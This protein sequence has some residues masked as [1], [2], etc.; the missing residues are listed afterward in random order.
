MI[1]ELLWLALL[2]ATFAGI[3]L[4]YKFFGKTG[5]YAWM[6][7]AIILANI[8]VLKTIGIFGFVTA[9]GNIVYGTTFLTTDILSEKYGQK[10]ARK[11]VWI[12]FFMLI[13][14]TIVMQVCLLFAP[15]ESDFSQGSLQTIFGFLPR[16]AFA[17]LLAFIV[18]Q[19]HDVWSFGLWK[20]KTKGKYLW[21]RNNASTLVSQLIDNVIFTAIAFTGFLSWVPFLNWTQVFDWSI[22]IQIFFVSYVMKFIVA[23][24]DTPFV[25]WAKKITPRE[26]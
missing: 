9:L 10:A 7:V 6:A 3:M 17:S 14:T 1:N 21:L 25:Y 5:L 12:G 11:A 18:S 16:I 13:A 15:H 23:A 2:L 4:A 20:K 19:H 26:D 8:Q 22:I 24:L